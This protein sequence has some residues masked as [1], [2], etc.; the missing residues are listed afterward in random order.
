M[1]KRQIGAKTMNTIQIEKIL[2]ESRITRRYF[3]G[4]FAADKI[5]KEIQKFPCSMVVNLDRATNEG[6]HW[7]AIY[8]RNQTTVYIFDSLL[9]P[10]LPVPI[11]TFLSQFPK[12]I[13]NKFP[14]QNPLSK[15]C[16]QH[17]IVFLYFISL[18]YTYE[19]YLLILNSCPNPD[20][21]VKSFVN[22]LI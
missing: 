14:V 13:K 21:F 16:G 15:E 8:I 6:S 1:E 17:C 5:P 11:K 18:G 12:Q 19:K 9:I 10:I 3:I 2:Y 22:K 4:C 7:I 20:E